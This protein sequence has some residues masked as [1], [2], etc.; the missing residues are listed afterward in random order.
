[1]NV[2][3]TRSSTAALRLIQQLAAANKEFETGKAALPGAN[4]EL[5]STPEVKPQ[6]KGALLDIFC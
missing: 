3:D 6:G 2:S 5:D 1:M 4:P